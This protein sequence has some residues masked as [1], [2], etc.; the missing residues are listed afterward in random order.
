[1]ETPT[2]IYQPGAMAASYGVSYDYKIVDASEVG[3]C[4]KNGW[5]N[6]YYDFPKKRKRGPN[7]AKDEHASESEDVKT[8]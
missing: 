3:N 1:M 4:L 7:K 6:H 5:Y 8:E 2:M